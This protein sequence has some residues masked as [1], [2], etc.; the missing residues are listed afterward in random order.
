[1]KEQ[2]EERAEEVAGLLGGR[3]RPPSSHCLGLAGNCITIDG[4]GLSLNVQS[5]CDIRNYE[6][7]K[8]KG[9]IC[10]LP[11]VIKTMRIGMDVFL[12]Q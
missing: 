12:L 9:M 11:N 2:T 1:M 4:F 10:A 8:N 6:Q 3:R 7:S 5:W